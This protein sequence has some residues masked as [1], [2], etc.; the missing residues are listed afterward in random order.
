MHLVGLQ[1]SQQINSIGNLMYR[2]MQT[3]SPTAS[4]DG[5]RWATRIITV[6]YTRAANGPMPHVGQFAARI[7]TC[8]TNQLLW[9]TVR[10]EQ[11]DTVQSTRITN[12]P[13]L[14]I[15]QIATIVIMRSSANRVRRWFASTDV[16]Q[17]SAHVP[18]TDRSCAS[19]DLQHM[20]WCAQ[21][22]VAW[23]TLRRA[24]WLAA[25]ERLCQRACTAVHRLTHSR[26]FAR[27]YISAVE[28]ARFLYLLH[29]L[30]FQ[31]AKIVLHNA[32]AQASKKAVH[33]TTK[34]VYLFHSFNF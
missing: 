27:T 29:D 18:Q 13:L 24:M 6:Q 33:R 4:A 10:V 28:I 22:P 2:T 8:T 1:N 20:Y 17:Y 23:A 15:G 11:C 31:W 21:S 5:S 34:C 25:A 7:R 26:T 9:A 30:L 12:R 16:Q 3:R 14:R 19:I 32:N